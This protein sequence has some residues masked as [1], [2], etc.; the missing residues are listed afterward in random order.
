VLFAKMPHARFHQLVD[1]GF[2]KTTIGVEGQRL[3]SEHA[4]AGPTPSPDRRG[5]SG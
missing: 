3:E 4:C 1:R 2:G 5:G